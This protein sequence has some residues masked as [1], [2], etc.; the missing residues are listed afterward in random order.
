[1]VLA[2][3]FAVVPA[4]SRSS[5][6]GGDAA[7]C[8]ARVSALETEVRALRERLHDVTAAQ[9]CASSKSSQ[10]AHAGLQGKAERS[11]ATKTSKHACDPAF[12]VD[13]QG[14]K[15]FKPDCFSEE[16]P[17]AACKVPFEYGAD[18]VKLFKLAC[19]D[20]ASAPAPCDLPYAFDSS[21][22]KTYKAECLK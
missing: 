21:G 20:F 5:T 16:T 7:I 9:G 18:G 14:I 10:S 17:A 13:E 19:L 12:S 2:G 6:S 15:S 8:E 3:V 22:V 11:R 1:V 4:Q